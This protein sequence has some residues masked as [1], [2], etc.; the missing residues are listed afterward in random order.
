MNKSTYWEQL[1]DPRWQRKRLEVMERANF[2]CE[3]CGDK[4]S[5]LNVH[6][7]AYL[8]GRRPWEY[9]QCQLVCLCETCHWATE[10]S[11][12]TARCLLSLMDQ[13]RRDEA[14]NYLWSMFHVDGEALG[15]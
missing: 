13:K 3:Q 2:T 12:N 11:I 8:K 15:V 9:E 5:T 6:H 7:M 14:I 4:A 10:K 1:R